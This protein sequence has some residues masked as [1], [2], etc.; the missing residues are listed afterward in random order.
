MSKLKNIFEKKWYAKLIV[1]IICLCIT[2]VS[3]R[4]TKEHKEA[5]KEAGSEYY[6]E[7]EEHL[8]STEEDYY[9]PMQRD[10]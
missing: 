6:V 7:P 10:Y 9:G 2:F 3:I 5:A 1:F 4:L 8:G